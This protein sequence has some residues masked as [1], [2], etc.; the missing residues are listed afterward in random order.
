MG[1]RPESRWDSQNQTL[2]RTHT[3]PGPP[4]PKSGPQNESV[5]LKG[6]LLKAENRKRAG[7]VRLGIQKSRGSGDFDVAAP[8]DRRAPLAE[9]LSGC[10]ENE[11]EGLSG[12]EF[13][14]KFHIHE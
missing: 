14:V 10:P 4:H 7:V 6:G 13:T 1:F 9:E 11:R 8:G 5:H 12:A 2:P 3:P